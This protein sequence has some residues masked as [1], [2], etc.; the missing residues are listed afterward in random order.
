MPATKEPVSASNPFYGCIIFVIAIL[1]FGGMVAWTLYSGWKQSKEI[2]TFT[3]QDA[4]PL[5]VRDITEAEKAAVKAK[6]EAFAADARAKKPATLALTADEMNQI[7]T[8]AEQQGVTGYRGVLHVTK[9]DHAAGRLESDIRWKMNNL[10]F[11]NAKDR[12][13]VGAATLVPKVEKGSFDLYVTNVTV[14]GKTVPAGFIGQLG[15]FAWLNLAKQNAQVA[16]VLKFVTAYRFSA[17]GPSLVLE[18]NVPAK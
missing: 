18:A 16:E 10:P 4:A 11:S 1:T 2:D 13:L 14:P 8:L 7:T 17:E 3:T 6:L 9:V 15:N 5:A 12:F